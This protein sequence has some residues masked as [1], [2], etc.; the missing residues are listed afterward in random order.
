MGLMNKCK[1]IN[2]KGSCETK[3]VFSISRFIEYGKSILGS[4]L[5]DLDLRFTYVYPTKMF[6]ICVFCVKLKVL[7][8]ETTLRTRITKYEGGKTKEFV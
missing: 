4:N 7:R 5:I 8:F 2:L 1:E 6:K 3:V